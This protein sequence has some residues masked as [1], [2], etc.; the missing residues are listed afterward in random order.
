MDQFENDREGDPRKV[1]SEPPSPKKDWGVDDGNKFKL[2]DNVYADS[3]P[4][5]PLGKIGK[6]YTDA[7]TWVI[8]E[9]FLRIMARKG[10][11]FLQFDDH[12]DKS[13]RRTRDKN[14]KRGRKNQYYT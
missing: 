4:A 6:E 5:N 1:K 10:G 13:Y 12:M 8:P 11:D 9:E 3:Q 7:E 2:E 14:K